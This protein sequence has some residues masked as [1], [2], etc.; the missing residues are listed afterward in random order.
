MNKNANIRFDRLSK[1]DVLHLLDS[2]PEL[3]FELTKAFMEELSALNV[4]MMRRATNSYFQNTRFH[5]LEFLHLS[6][7][8]FVNNFFNAF[9][10]STLKQ[11]LTTIFQRAPHLVGLRIPLPCPPNS[12][13]QT[14]SFSEIAIPKGLTYLHLFS[15]AKDTFV[16]LYSVEHLHYFHLC[17]VD[18]FVSPRKPRDSLDD[19]E[20]EF[21]DEIDRFAPRGPRLYLGG[22]SLHV[23]L[24]IFRE[25]VRSRP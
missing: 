5:R 17:L 25:I 2:D 3:S 7:V 22:S 4:R 15:K 20:D 12:G 19:D 24:S 8:S 14:I 10:A 16:D 18:V 6:P 11:V 13:T 1:V 21:E 23:T 9:K